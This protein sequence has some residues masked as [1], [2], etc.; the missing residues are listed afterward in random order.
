MYIP[1]FCSQLQCFGKNNHRYTDKEQNLSSGKRQ[2]N[3]SRMTDADKASG[4]EGRNHLLTNSQGQW[5][6]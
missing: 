5:F 2:V 4:R 3:Q 1:E 6:V